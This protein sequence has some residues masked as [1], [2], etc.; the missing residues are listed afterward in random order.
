VHIN[1][2]TEGEPIE[3]GRWRV[4]FYEHAALA[5]CHREHE[6][7]GIEQNESNDCLDSYWEWDLQRWKSFQ[8]ELSS[9]VTVGVHDRAELTRLPPLP[10]ILDVEVFKDILF[11]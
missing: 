6:W 2:N 11:K 4:W 9:S 10:M 3:W 7:G 8:G 1:R 5:Q